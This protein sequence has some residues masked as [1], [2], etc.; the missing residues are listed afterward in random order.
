MATGKPHGARSAEG[1]HD[2]QQ[3]VAR[4]EGHD[5]QTGFDKHDQEKQ[6]IDPNAV[7]LD[8]FGQVFVDVEDEIN[9]K[10]CDVHPRIIG[11]AS[12]QSRA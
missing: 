3:R 10:V 2:E 8:E 11:A 9:Q 1:A 7:H 12:V 6:G 4:Q 5:D